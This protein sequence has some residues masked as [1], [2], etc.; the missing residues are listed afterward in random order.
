MYR[1][2]TGGFIEVKLEVTVT[3]VD[4]STP[5]CGLWRVSG[6][7]PNELDSQIQKF[8]VTRGLGEKQVRVNKKITLVR[9]T[10]EGEW[11]KADF[12]GEH[13]FDKPSGSTTGIPMQLFESISGG[14]DGTRGCMGD[15]GRA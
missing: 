4:G 13:E 15:C 12:H 14:Q 11:A 1:L 7:F 10:A 6:T 8:G 2:I 9:L 5:L 3:P